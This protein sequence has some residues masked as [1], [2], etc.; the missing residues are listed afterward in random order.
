MLQNCVNTVGS[1]E[2][3]C[4]G[5]YIMQEDGFTCNPAATCLGRKNHVMLDNDHFLVGAQ[6]RDFITQSIQSKFDNK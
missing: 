3:S 4:D 2:C 1:F 5:A 6:P